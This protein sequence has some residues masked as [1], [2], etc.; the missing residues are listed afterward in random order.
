ME[1][2]RERERERARCTYDLGRVCT[3]VVCVFSCG[4]LGG[5]GLEGLQTSG[6]TKQLGSSHNHG[7][8][9][10][11]H[12]KLYAVTSLDALCQHARDFWYL[13]PLCF[14]AQHIAQRDGDGDGVEDDDDHCPTY[15]NSSRQ[16][17]Q[18]CFLKVALI[19][20]FPILSNDAK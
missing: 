18:P 6:L 9:R 3:G 16:A 7:T 20:R 10:F 4:G 15:Y 19:P 8:E 14:F 5:G 11:T 17:L 2:G 12:Q 1:G 13:Q